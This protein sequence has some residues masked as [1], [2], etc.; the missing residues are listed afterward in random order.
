MVLLSAERQ[1]EVTGPVCPSRIKV[2]IPV[3]VLHI[4]QV[5]SALADITVDPS[6][7]TETEVTKE[8]WPLSCLGG[9]VYANSSKKPESKLGNCENFLGTIFVLGTIA[10]EVI[11]Q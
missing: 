8:E 9:R 5:A 2:G 6:D 4:R 1:I 7:D 3:S 11:S 10:M